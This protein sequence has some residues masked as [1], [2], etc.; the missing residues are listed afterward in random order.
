MPSLVEHGQ[1]V[2][3]ACWEGGG[4]GRTGRI[5]KSVAASVLFEKKQKALQ[6]ACR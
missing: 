4:G 1:D 2:E 3:E 6:H 5:R